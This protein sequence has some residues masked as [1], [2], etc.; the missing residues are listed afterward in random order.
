MEYFVRCILHFAFCIF[1][2]VFFRLYFSFCILYFLFCIC[3]S[4]QKGKNG[5]VS[6]CLLLAGHVLLAT[7]FSPPR[8]LLSFLVVYLLRLL[9]VAITPPAT[10]PS[11]PSGWPVSTS[12]L[13]ISC[14]A[15]PFSPSWSA[16]WDPKASKVGSGNWSSAGVGSVEA[17]A[18]VGQSIP[19]FTT[20]AAI[21][22]SCSAGLS[23]LGAGAATL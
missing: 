21:V 16:C 9:V 8:W 5:L 11:P 4:S 20:A 18:G 2:F 3:C 22:V 10:A 14:F 7:V 15:S 6:T 17:G 13:R 19:D 1:P 23:V 12:P